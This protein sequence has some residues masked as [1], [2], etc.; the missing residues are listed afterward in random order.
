MAVHQVKTPTGWRTINTKE[1]E[2]CHIRK[3]RIIGGSRGPAGTAVLRLFI[4]T[5]S[6]DIETMSAASHAK[7]HGL[8]NG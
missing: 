4:I 8:R 7:R 6:K 1:R 3:S 5:V 2:V